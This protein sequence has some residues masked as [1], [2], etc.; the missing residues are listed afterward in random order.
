MQTDIPGHSNEP[1]TA[2]F[3]LDDLHGNLLGD[4]GPTLGPDYTSLRD[5]ITDILETPSAPPPFLD[6]RPLPEVP[7]DRLHRLPLPDP[8]DHPEVEPLLQHE[9]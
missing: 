1:L 3:Q 7:Q 5:Y 9:V 4:A 8:L 2:T 6:R